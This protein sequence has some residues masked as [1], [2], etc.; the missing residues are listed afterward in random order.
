MLSLSLF[1]SRLRQTH[2]AWTGHEYK[3]VVPRLAGTM[4]GAMDALLTYSG[5]R[6]YSHDD[7]E[8]HGRSEE[9]GSFNSMR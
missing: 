4:D 3:T 7:R 2:N 5:M 9:E 6:G 8:G 1:R